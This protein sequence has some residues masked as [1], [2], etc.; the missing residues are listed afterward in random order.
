ELHGDEAADVHA[1]VLD[2]LTPD[3]G[4]RDELRP[5]AM[6]IRATDVV[7]RELRRVVDDGRVRP[8]VRALPGRPHPLGFEHAA[9]VLA[10]PA[11]R[12][13]IE[14]ADRSAGVGED[15]PGGRLDGGLRARAFAGLAA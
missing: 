12:G 6:R 15:L 8:A 11:V 3:L 13:R 5:E 4:S 9:D 7:R 1:V 14:R 2:D 10:H